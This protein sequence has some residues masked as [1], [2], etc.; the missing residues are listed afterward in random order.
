MHCEFFLTIQS[1]FFIV[2]LVNDSNNFLKVCMKVKAKQKT[3]V[4]M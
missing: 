4:N 3:A 2:K 1:V